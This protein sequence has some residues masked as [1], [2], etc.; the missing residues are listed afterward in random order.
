[1]VAAAPAPAMAPAPAAAAAPAPVTGKYEAFG[2]YKPIQKGVTGGLNAQQEAYL[3][4][5]IK[6]YAARTRESK[7][8]TQEQRARLADP[9]VASGFRA[10]WKEIVYPIHIVRSAGSKLWDADGNEYIDILNGFGVTMFGHRPPFVQEAIEKQ[11]REGFEIGPQT[12]LA[13]EVASLICEFTGMERATF[14]NTGS[15]AVMA[16]MRLARTVTNKNKVC[17]FAGDYHGAFDEVLVKAAG[18]PGSAPRCRPIAPGIPDEKAANVIVLEYGS[19]A[20]L[21]IIRAHAHEL[22]AVMVEPVQSRHPNLQPVEFLRELRAITE[23]SNIA[24]IF[25][26]VVTGFRTHP[27]GAQA[28]FDIRADMATYGKVI[29]GGMPVGVLAG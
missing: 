22:A 24:L 18:K 29:G 5:F 17:F 1:V 7:R 14:C 23:Q 28:L 16:A 8:L 27:G 20:S 12:P 19:P 26:E 10:Q 11:V 6:R 2:P 21:E 4:A 15:E 9:R 25:D 3:A 13:G